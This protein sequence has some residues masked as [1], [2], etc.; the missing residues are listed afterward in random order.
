MPTTASFLRG[1]MNGRRQIDG[2]NNVIY[3]EFVTSGETT[4]WR[5][6]SNRPGNSQAKEPMFEQHSEESLALNVG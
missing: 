5:R 1:L 4:R 3:D 2:F 6:R